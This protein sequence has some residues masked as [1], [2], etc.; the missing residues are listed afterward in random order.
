[1]SIADSTQSAPQA[2]LN[3]GALP[4]D[5][6][7]GGGTDAGAPGPGWQL[8]P[9]PF[10]L[11][12][13][14]HDKLLRLGAL[15]HRFMRAIDLLYRQSRNENLPVPAWVGDLYDRGKPDA[16]IQFAR[17]NRFKNR[18]PL[19]IRPDLMLNEQQDW[20]LTEIDAVPGGIGFTS[21]LNHAYRQSGF[22]V[23][24]ADGGMPRAFVDML[25]AGVPDVPEPQIAI[26]LS[27]EAADYRREMDW[28]V[29]HI[30]EFYP[31]MALVHPRD[32]DLVRDRLVFEEAGES[33][34]IDLIY[35]FFELFD[36]PNIPKMELIQYAVKKGLAACTPPFKPHLEEKLSLALLHHPGLRDFWRSELGEADFEQLKAWVPRGWVMDPAPLPPHAVIPD[37]APGGSVVQDYRQLKT[38]SQKG[39]ELVIKPSGFSELAWGSRGVTIGHDHSADAWGDQVDAALAA[40]AHTPHVLQQ[41]VPATAHPLRRLDLETGQITEFKARTRLCPYYFVIGDEVRLAGVLATSTPADKKLIHGMKDAVLAPAMVAD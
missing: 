9:E 22:A 27:D 6:L 34:P 21:A 17:N 15:L 8:S 26:V 24:E 4:G 18:L 14:Q 12:A 25:K 2:I 20:A 10:A 32:I 16:L 3:P 13:D 29:G 35:R 30:R 36:L 40:F 38:L 33:R 23:L 39:R 31:R 19:V 1:M 7:Y 28:L 37:L 5:P 11:S 41:F